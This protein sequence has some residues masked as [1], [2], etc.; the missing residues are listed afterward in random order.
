MKVAIPPEFERF[1]REQ[2]AAGHVTS[3]EEAV[4]TALRGY[5]EDLQTLQGL[6][7]P[8]LAAADRGEL[9][10]G[11]AFMSELLEETRAIVEAAQAR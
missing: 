10:D 6:L 4:A 5:L 11:E 7:T 2:V 1:A 8:A 9:V 3:E